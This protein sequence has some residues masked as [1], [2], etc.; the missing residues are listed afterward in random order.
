M[1]N[2]CKKCG[3]FIW[4]VKSAHKCREVLF[5]I[6][7]YDR[8]EDWHSIYTSWSFGN[9]GYTAEKIAEKHFN[10]E[11]RDHFECSVRIK[12]VGSDDVKFFDVTGEP[13]MNFDATE[14]IESNVEVTMK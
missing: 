10:E 8:D 3:Y 11:P 14:K 4:T 7:D 6:V 12:E 9:L 13:I 2:W 5:Q 1:D